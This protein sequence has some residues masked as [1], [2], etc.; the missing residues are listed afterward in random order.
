MLLILATSLFAAG[1]DAFTFNPPRPPEL[2][3]KTATPVG[4]GLNSSSAKTVEVILMPRI[5][6]DVETLKSTTRL[7]AGIDKIRVQVTAPPVEAPASAQAELVRKVVER[8]PPAL[9]IE[10]PKDPVPELIEAVAEAR[11]AGIPVVAVGYPLGE[12][13]SSEASS[14]SARPI[15][16]ATHK[17]FKPSVR[18][19]VADA[20]RCARNGEI[21]PDSGAVILVDETV[22]SL[23]RARADAIRDALK[24]AGVKKIEELPFARSIKA[25]KQKLIEY[26][27]AH[28][29]T[30][31][32]FATDAGGIA[33]AD[34]A[35]EILKKDHRYVIAGF[36]DNEAAR[37]QVQMG[38]YAAIAVFSIDRLLRRGVN[39]ASSLMRG[40]EVPDRVEIEVPAVESGEKAALPRMR[41][42]PPEKPKM[43]PKMPTPPPE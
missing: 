20:M 34:D 29:E 42:E 9:V 35:T 41:V 18:I 24:E 19:V 3:T 30:T 36:S 8:K 13:K 23:V 43:T 32:V 22:D 15:V 25:A 1:C 16:L 17:D 4:A 11:K 38:E 31:M 6:A 33:A 14:S 2:V 39:I 27:K 28:K 5:E 21:A 10:A 7:Q 37:N 40:V 12:S 26:L